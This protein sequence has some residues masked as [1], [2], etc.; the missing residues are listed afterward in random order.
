[1]NTSNENNYDFLKMQETP[2]DF[3]DEQLESMMDS[4]DDVP[5]VEDE[6]KKFEVV[7]LYECNSSRKQV[8]MKKAASIIVA[9]F[10]IGIA[11]AASVATGFIPYVFS[12]HDECEQHDEAL[13]SE[14]T[15]NSSA[16]DKKEKTVILF[17]NV[18]LKDIASEFSAYYNIKVDFKDTKAK[19]VRLYFN[20]DKSASLE[21]NIA[22]LN[23]FEKINIRLE[24]N[25]LIVE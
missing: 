5:D 7:H 19:D 16:E 12:A 21:D 11:C 1:M 2:E 10:L 15:L 13:S 14:M 3:T 6:W 9:I 24:N 8:W 25:T 18:T 23:A 20:W 4:M 17:D 22:V